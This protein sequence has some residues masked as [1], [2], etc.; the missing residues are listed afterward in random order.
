M[1]ISKLAKKPKL[2]K[3]DISDSDIVEKF[4]EEISFYIVDQM[5]VSTYFDF[6]KLQQT[7][8]NELLNELLRKLILKEDGTSALAPDEVFPVSLT[9]AVLMRIND[10]L[11]EPETQPQTATAGNM[12]N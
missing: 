9:L 7:Q 12:Q 10:F 11:A 5:G 3:L 8:D 6:Y 2:V 4:G 1:D